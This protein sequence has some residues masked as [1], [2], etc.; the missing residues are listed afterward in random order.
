MV[1]WRE[2]HGWLRVSPISLIRMAG[3][4]SHATGI[5]KVH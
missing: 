2:E 5:T 4:N 3:G 1:E